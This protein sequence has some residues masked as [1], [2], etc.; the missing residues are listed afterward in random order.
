MCKVET[1]CG[2]CDLT[3]GILAIAIISSI[4]LVILLPFMIAFPILLINTAE[5]GR[6][7][8]LNRPM[9]ITF[10]LFS[11]ILLIRVVFLWCAFGN[12]TG[13]MSN[14]NKHEGIH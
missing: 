3:V 4:G 14:S 2:C 5:F 11:L 9:A 8:G 7:S 12:N 13:T 10:L 1:C 6:S